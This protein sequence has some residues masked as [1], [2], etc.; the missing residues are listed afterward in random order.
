MEAR[1]HARSNTTIPDRA[2]CGSHRDR[3][4]PGRRLHRR[5]GLL[6][7]QCRP[8]AR[9]RRDAAT[10]HAGHRALLGPG[11]HGVQP[12]PPVPQ[13]AP[14]RSS[15]SPARVSRRGGGRGHRRTPLACTGTHARAARDQRLAAVLRLLPRAGLRVALAGGTHG[16]AAVAARVDP[17][18]WTSPPL[19]DLEN[20]KELHMHNGWMAAFFLATMATD[21]GSTE[22]AADQLWQDTYDARKQY[23]E[24]AVGP[25]PRD[26]LKMINMIG[27]WPGGG[28][29]VIP[30]PGTGEGMAVYTTFGLS[31]PDLLEPPRDG[32]AGYGYEAIVVAPEG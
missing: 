21:A 23:F 14:A 20:Q 13:C 3:D 1:I 11:D 27:I 15:T 7:R 9:A 32:R 25:F 17:R 19:S 22:Q 29:F 5:L 12:L 10:G 2:R 4:G 6:G 16:G 18:G 24:G 26:I 30:A 31:N 8:Q 28:L